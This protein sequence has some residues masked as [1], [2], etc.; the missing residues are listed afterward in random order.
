M[1]YKQLVAAASILLLITYIGCL[2]STPERSRDVLLF[3]FWTVTYVALGAVCFAALVA[4]VARRR[5]D[6]DP[7]PHRLTA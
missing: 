5:G 1:T 7:E 2:M 4:A 3:L 6:P